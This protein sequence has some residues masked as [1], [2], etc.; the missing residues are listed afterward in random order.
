M[1]QRLGW[2]VRDVLNTQSYDHRAL[3]VLSLLSFFL[4]SFVISVRLGSWSFL[5][6]I[7]HDFILRYQVGSG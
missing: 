3:V 4:L 7:W 2:V 6:Y 1:V 5:F